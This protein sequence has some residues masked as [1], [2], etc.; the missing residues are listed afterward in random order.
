MLVDLDVSGRDGPL[1]CDDALGLRS[2]FGVSA[3]DGPEGAARAASSEYERRVG[4]RERADPVEFGVLD[5]AKQLGRVGWRYAVRERGHLGRSTAGARRRGE[6]RLRGVGRDS[7]RPGVDGRRR[8]REPRDESG[9]DFGTLCMCAPRVRE[10][11]AMRGTTRP[12]EE[13]GTE[14]G[15]RQKEWN[16]KERE[17]SSGRAARE[18]R[19]SGSPGTGVIT[20]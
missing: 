9:R 1:L 19:T 3:V 13:R 20:S 12:R 7:E 10:S 15:L 5:G 14:D 6:R 11:L 18:G 17:T 2:G 8:P 4:G 16:C